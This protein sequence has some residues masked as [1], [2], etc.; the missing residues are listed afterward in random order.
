MSRELLG[1][2]EW[3]EH[4]TLVGLANVARAYGPRHPQ[5]QNTALVAAYTRATARAHMGCAVHVFSQNRVGRCVRPMGHDGPHRDLL[6][7]LADSQA[8]LAG[9]RRV[10]EPDPIPE[11]GG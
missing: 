2:Y 1:P 6:L 4:P 5:T 11:V 7:S 8:I 10:V 9:M 3:I